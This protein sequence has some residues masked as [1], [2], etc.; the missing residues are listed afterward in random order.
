MAREQ[1]FLSNKSSKLVPRSVWPLLATKLTEGQV[2]AWAHLS[3]LSGRSQTWESENGAPRLFIV[4]GCVHWEMSRQGHSVT[5]P[6]SDTESLGRTLSQI[7]MQ[8]T[9]VSKCNLP[10]N[11]IGQYM[12]VILFYRMADKSLAE[13]GWIGGCPIPGPCQRRT[14]PTK[15][16]QTLATPT[17]SCS[18]ASF[19]I[20]TSHWR[21]KTVCFDISRAQK[22][23]CGGPTHVNANGE[24]EIGSPQRG[25]CSEMTKTR[26]CL[27]QA[28]GKLF[29]IN[30]KQSSKYR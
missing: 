14:I 25:Y 28:D 13:A 24:Y 6:P 2:R 4:A 29:N 9:F 21:L 8:T 3:L 22:K 7:G 18:L 27:Q 16:S 10:L 23:L 19:W 12:N 1:C 26:E 15:T 20:M 11:L 17:W 5:G 30:Y